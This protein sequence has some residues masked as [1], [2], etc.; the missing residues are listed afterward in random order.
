MK[1][2]DSTWVSIADSLAGGVF[3]GASFIHLIPE[4]SHAFHDA[5]LP[6][7][8]F[9]CVGAIFIMVVF[10]VF[11]NPSLD[12]KECD[13]NDNDGRELDVES[14]ES[15][16]LS[17]K[18]TFLFIMILIHSFFESLSLGITKDNASFWAL[19]FA[20]IAHK[21]VVCFALGL[22]ILS[23]KVST[24]LYIILMS[25]FIF[26]APLVTVSFIYIGQSASAKFAG[27]M[28]AIS[29]GVFIF[30]GFNEMHVLLHTKLSRSDKIWHII[31]F[32]VGIL[33]M[34]LVAVF[35]GE[36]SH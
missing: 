22:A 8:P 11:Q 31:S 30:V 27:I 25:I 7:V 36:H 4:S 18:N 19:F 28:N 15:P 26:S 16:S 14:N 35:V 20:I 5:H 32:F 12:L 10:D 33:W 29:S 1:F 3:L 21:P 6:I 24:K 2:K 17:H 34:A 13:A 9:F 23:D